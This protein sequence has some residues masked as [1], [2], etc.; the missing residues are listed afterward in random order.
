MRINGLR[1]ETKATLSILI[2]EIQDNLPDA[3]KVRDLLASWIEA[4]DLHPENVKKMTEKEAMLMD[5]EFSKG[6][7]GSTGP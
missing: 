4:N 1:A 2:R 6:C 5:S 7:V 3:N